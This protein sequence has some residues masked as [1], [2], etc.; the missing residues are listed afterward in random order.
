M[1]AN[2]SI[3]LLVDGKGEEREGGRRREGERTV[4]M[5]G[6][7]EREGEGEGGER[8]VIMRGDGEREGEQS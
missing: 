6:D 8:T 2:S 4:I 7:G 3:L 1:P 5:R